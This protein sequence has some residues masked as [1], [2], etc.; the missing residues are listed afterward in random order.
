M[1]D[2]NIKVRDLE[3]VFVLRMEGVR[4]IERRVREV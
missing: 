3:V 4:C 2:R 1:S